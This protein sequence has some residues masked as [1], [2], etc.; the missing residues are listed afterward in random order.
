MYHKKVTLIINREHV[1]LSTALI[2]YVVVKDRKTVLHMPGD[3]QYET[4][5]PL[6]RLEQ[7]LGNGFLRINRDCLVSINAIHKIQESNVE[8]VNGETLI[9]S[10]R[11]R[12]ALREIMYTGR[13]DIIAGLDRSG[14]PTTPEEYQAHYEAFDTLPIAFTDIE[15]VFNEEYLAT[16][17]RF[18]YVNSALA[19]LEK[20]T[21]EQLLENS[22]RTLF[23]NMDDKWLCVYERSALYGETLEI[24]DYSPE[25]DTYLK[26]ICFPTFRGHCG[27][28]L[29]DL[30]Q[31]QLARSNAAGEKTLEMYINGFIQP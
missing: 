5:T 27:C 8:L 17:W 12:R 24:M 16:D 4:Y 10:R 9:C 21:K 15:I 2:L 3:R 31:I 22:F 30:S 6:D 20:H 29:F 25:I 19:K 23:P 14:I 26:I 18:C 13:R 7:E 28:L 11:R 1:E